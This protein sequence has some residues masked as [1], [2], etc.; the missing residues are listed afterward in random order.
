MRGI[1][2]LFSL[3][4]AACVAQAAE[5]YRW[6]DATGRVHYSDQPPPPE[7]RNP[8][9]RRLG[10][11]PAASSLPYAL[12]EAVRQFPVTVYTAEGCGE[13]CKQG[14]AYLARR[15]VPFTEKDA[16]IAENADV[17]MS[18]AGGK[19]EVPLMVIGR[20]AVRGFE[21]STW[22]ANLDAAGYPRSSTLPPGMAARQAEPSRVAED[23]SEQPAEQPADANPEPATN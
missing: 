7:V 4:V 18:H 15:G 14:L 10:D 21:E 9:R 11:K 1:A 13:G 19:L 12:Q 17:V 8:E 2:L 23:T 20:S 6:V 5:M 22:A 3:A 16:R